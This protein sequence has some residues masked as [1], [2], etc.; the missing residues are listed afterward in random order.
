[1]RSVPQQA[2]PGLLHRASSGGK[3]ERKNH[4]RSSG[5]PPSFSS[6]IAVQSFQQGRRAQRR[7]SFFV[8]TGTQKNWQSQYAERS[9]QLQGSLSG[10]RLL[11]LPILIK[12]SDLSFAGRQRQ[13]AVGEGE[14]GGRGLQGIPRQCSLMQI[15]SRQQVEVFSSPQVDCGRTK[16]VKMFLKWRTKVIPHYRR[17]RGFGVRHWVSVGLDTSVVSSSS[18]VF[19]SVFLSQK[20]KS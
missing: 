17:M 12:P 15:Q 18:Y 3:A 9:G 19:A 4:N 10:S 2:H 1:M 16:T 20:R 11:H 8:E 6:L 7:I 5:L 14:G 13:G